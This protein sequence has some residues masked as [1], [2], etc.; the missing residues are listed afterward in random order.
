M[1]TALPLHSPASS[2]FTTAPSRSPARS[3]GAC[4]RT[5]RFPGPSPPFPSSTQ[6]AARWCRPST[7][8][9][10]RPPA[11][12][13]CRHRRELKDD[14]VHSTGINK[15]TSTRSF[16]C[17]WNAPVLISRQTDVWLIGLM[18]GRCKSK[19]YHYRL[20]LFSVLLNMPMQAS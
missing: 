17:T 8:T 18:M 19:Q 11:C 15:Q 2:W 10:M 13:S 9:T 4:L 12:P 20:I 16:V 7:P 6:S 5:G 14:L 1:L 3:C